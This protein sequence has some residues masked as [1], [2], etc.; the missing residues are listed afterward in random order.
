MDT[1]IAIIIATF[2]LVVVVAFLVFRQPASFH[3]L[4]GL[5]A[6]HKYT[7]AN[8]CSLGP[9]PDGLPQRHARKQ[10]LAWSPA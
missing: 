2:A 6:F 8:K 3:C 9:R 1:T 7:L 4:P 5:M 10:M